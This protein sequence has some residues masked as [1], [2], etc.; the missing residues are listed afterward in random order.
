MLLMGGGIGLAALGSSVAFIAKS[1]QNVSVFTVIGVLFGIMLV[2]GGPCV[3]ISLNKL[4]RRDLA[5]FLEAAGCALNHSMRLTFILGLFFT[6]SPRRP[7]AL[8]PEMLE[9]KVTKRSILCPVVLLLILISMLTGGVVGIWLGGKV[10][11]LR[12]KY[13]S[14]RKN[15]SAGVV[16][17]AKKSPAAVVKQAEP[18]KTVPAVKNK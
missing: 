16:K 2:F 4:Y 14:G 1:L 18:A 17:C 13:A 9:S 7:G 10:V 3:V 6:F 5:R 12:E 15:T 8:G 11:T